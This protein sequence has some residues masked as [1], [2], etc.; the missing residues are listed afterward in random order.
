MPWIKRNLGF[1]ISLGVAVVLLGVGITY[2]MSNKGQ[3]DGVHAAL[4]A[5]NSELN[6]LVNR[7]PF[8]N[9]DNIA[10]AQREQKRLESIL[11]R[12]QP[13]F[14]VADI[15]QPLD[16]ASFKN[17][18]EN[19]IDTLT[20]KA[21]RSGV[22]LPDDKFSFTFEEQRLALQLPKA[23]LEP[24]AGH[25]L[26]IRTICDILFD[27]KVHTLTYVK[28]PVVGTNET[29]TASSHISGQVSTNE[30]TGA[31]VAPYEVTF[32]S[33]SSELAGVINRIVTSPEAISI[34]YIN[35]EKG[36]LDAKPAVGL[37]GMP[38]GMDP[39]LAQRYGLTPGG[40]GPGGTTPDRYGAPGGGRYGAPGGGRGAA[41]G[42]YGAP[43]G[44]RYGAPGAV[45]PGYGVPA[46]PGAPRPGDP[47]LDDKPIRVVLG[48]ELVHLPRPRAEQNPADAAPAAPS[49]FNY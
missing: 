39:A 14:T 24:L 28:R 17:L 12:V 37:G 26:N 25:L 43:G 27:A 32:N 44:G 6:R 40:P 22:K 41:G 19:T 31:S 4:E 30:T 35:V 18:L 46:V 20:R 42:R 5:K 13:H 16:N 10:S 29:L 45:P 8:P 1:V 2:L 48:L 49:N 33:F 21:K 34:K 11:E 9:E 3:A 15:P 36:S 47:V 23:S 7:D 38:G